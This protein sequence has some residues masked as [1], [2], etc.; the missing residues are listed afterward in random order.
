M[1][2][3]DCEVNSLRECAEAKY[4]PGSLLLDPIFTAG[5]REKNTPIFDHSFLPIRYVVEAEVHYYEDP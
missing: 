1:E 5:L 2:I 3:D 4:T